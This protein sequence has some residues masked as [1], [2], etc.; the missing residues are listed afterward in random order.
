MIAVPPAELR[1]SIWSADL[2]VA[3]VS[4]LD[5]SD[6]KA[7]KVFRGRGGGGSLAVAASDPDAA[8][9]QAGRVVRVDVAD[10]SGGWVPWHAWVLRT[11]KASSADVAADGVERVVWSGPEL[12]ALLDDVQVM[13]NGVGAAPFSDQ[14]V[15]DWSSPEL[16]DAGW[17]TPDVR[18]HVTDVDYPPAALA[19]RPTT[20]PSD[21]ALF[22]SGAPPSGSPGVDA[23]GLVPFR[24]HVALDAGSYT[25]Y[26][27]GDDLFDVRVD[28]V[29]MVAY[30]VAFGDASTATWYRQFR[31]TEP[32]AVVVSA[33]VENVERFAADPGAPF[34]NVLMFAASLH[35]R[36]FGGIGEEAE[37]MS[38][39]AAWLSHGPGPLPGFTAAQA[40][41]VMLLDAGG[42][43]LT[44]S[45]SGDVMPEFV[46]S[47]PSTVGGALDRLVALGWCDLRFAAD[48]LGFEVIDQDDTPGPPAAVLSVDDGDFAVLES[49]E[50]HST[51]AGRLLVRYA[52]GWVVVG[53][54][55]PMD[56][57]TLGDVVTEAAA[58]SAAAA[59]LAGLAEPR[60]RIAASIDAPA[61]AMPGVVWDVG[62]WVDLDGEI[63]RVA[64]LSVSE[65]ENGMA[66]WD[67]EFLTVRE[68]REE[69][70]SRVAERMSPGSL[71]GRS[72]AVAPAA[73]VQPAAGQMRPRTLVW[74]WGGPAVDVDP[75]S[76][77]VQTVDVLGRVT[78]IE[79]EVPE[80]K[81]PGSGGTTTAVLSVGGVAV[82]FAEVAEG[83]TRGVARFVAGV[84]PGQQLVVE[85]TGGHHED[86]TVQV[87]FCALP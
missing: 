51:V 22:L 23:V 28:G 2:S 43:T 83:A 71:G 8:E 49:V 60:R 29:P 85:L 13:P 66:V 62:D 76:A 38:T 73:D 11:K 17:S 54:D 57:V 37:V 69:R 26:V 45:T 31:L 18:G 81:A 15:F 30:R 33:L 9:V 39:D 58:A 3:H 74:S 72:S 34:G 78:M 46:V 19:G 20:F 86:G 67:P 1:W 77:K 25:L 16:D 61:T 52:N 36:T 80:G 6:G 35:H 21:T 48:S 59:M 40:V 87:T 10:G 56:A 32:R 5:V 53:A 75:A 41:D 82:A 50:E 27:T 70:L 4:D 47:C 55:G 79:V 68:E 12:S 65:D 63:V 14:R 84:A 42:W 7:S 64:G 24:R 44:D